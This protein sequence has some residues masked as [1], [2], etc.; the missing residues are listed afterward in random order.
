ML[1]TIFSNFENETYN[2]ERIHIHFM[3]AKR[4]FHFENFWVLD[5]GYT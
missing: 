3:T 4:L 5:T 1:L 2:F